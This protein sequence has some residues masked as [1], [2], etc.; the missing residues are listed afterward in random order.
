MESTWEGFSSVWTQVGL[1]VR[2]EHDLSQHTEPRESITHPALWMV[3]SLTEAWGA[4][5]EGNV[6]TDQG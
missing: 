5:L 1:S 2:G 3:P 6:E 4:L